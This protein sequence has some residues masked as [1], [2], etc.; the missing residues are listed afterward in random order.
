MRIFLHRTP[1]CLNHNNQ[2]VAMLSVFVTPS[3]KRYIPSTGILTCCPSTT[4]IGLVLGSDSPWAES[5]GPG[6]LGFSVEVILTL[7]IA[8]HFSIRSCVTSSAPYR[9]TFIS[10]HNAPLPVIKDFSSINSQ[11]R[12]KTLAPLHFRRRTTSPVS[13]YAFFKGWLLLSQPPGCQS[14][15]TTFTT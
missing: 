12:Y 11:L 10:K 14:S 3:V 9:Y 7:L 13:Y 6:T 5:P 1:T 4:P 8:T 15:S 2:S